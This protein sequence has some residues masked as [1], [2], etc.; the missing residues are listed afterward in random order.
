MNISRASL[1]FL[2]LAAGAFAC[3]VHDNTINIPNAMLNVTADVDVQNVE[4]GQSVPMSVNV[5]NV[6]LVEPTVT[7]PPEHAN[8][9]C[10]LK[11]FLDDESTPPLLVTAQTNVSVMIPPQT[12][13]GHHK[14]ICRVHKHDDT[15]TS[16]KFELDINVKATVTVGGGT[17]GAT[18]GGTGGASGTGGAA[19]A[20]DAAAPD[21]AAAD[22][23]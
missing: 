3:N 13:P 9:A 10:H 1:G 14:V 20:P 11:F 15:P 17:G 21:A 12:P 19:V 5:Q 22:A 8:D 6:Y 7:P 18:G 16:T 2:A 4:P 23:Y